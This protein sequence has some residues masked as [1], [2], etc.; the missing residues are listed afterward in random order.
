MELRDLFHLSHNCKAHYFPAHKPTRSFSL[1]NVN[2]PL[3]GVNRAFAR[4]DRSKQ[5]E[6][7][8]KSYINERKLAAVVVGGWKSIFYRTPVGI[9]SL[10]G[11]WVVRIVRCWRT[12]N[13]GGRVH[14][15]SWTTTRTTTTR[16]STRGRGWSIYGLV[17]TMLTHRRGSPGS[18]TFDSLR[19][20]VELYRHAARKMHG[21][22]VSS[23]CRLRQISQRFDVE[24][25]NLPLFASHDVCLR[26]SLEHW[27]LNGIG[28]LWKIVES[29]LIYEF[30][31]QCQRCRIPCCSAKASQ[32]L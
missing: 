27:I 9:V 24:G 1:P 13:S 4:S 14:R 32:S 25:T 15:P 29:I 11:F 18:S 23:G 8:C 19:Y 16:T 10:A 17:E 22:C 28:W 30:A 2:Y 31:D 26:F 20:L 6:V 5:V 7:P 21:H 3:A 12:K